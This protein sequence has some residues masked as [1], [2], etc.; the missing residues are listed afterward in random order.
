MPF[1]DE[2]RYSILGRLPES[3]ELQGVAL[4]GV[5]SRIAVYIARKPV[6]AQRNIS[7]RAEYLDSATLFA[8]TEAYLKV[9]IGEEIK[10]APDRLDSSDRLESFGI[11][12]IMIN[13]LN[14]NLDRDLGALP[15]TLLY[16][17]ETIG[18]VAKFLLKEAREALTVLF[19]SGEAPSTEIEE[20]ATQA[21]VSTSQQNEDLIAI[22]GIH[23]SYPHSPNLEEYW[24]NLKQGET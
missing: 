17:H 1:A 6:K 22:I 13:R 10:L 23:G 12:S 9:L 4:Y 3:D 2:R 7:A 24:E 18:E 21:V 20:E 14:S 15:K 11:D 19:G 8:K 16:E 5:P